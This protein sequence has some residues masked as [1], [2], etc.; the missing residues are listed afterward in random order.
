MRPE[1]ISRPVDERH[2][3]GSNSRTIFKQLDRPA[4][5]AGANGFAEAFSLN[6][7]AISVRSG[8]VGEVVEVV[9]VGETGWGKTV[10]LAAAD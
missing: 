10:T 7:T 5:A 9:E 1:M 2:L 4:L 8:E 3:P 6:A